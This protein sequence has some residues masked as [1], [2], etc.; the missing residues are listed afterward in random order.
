MCCVYIHMAFVICGNELQ[1]L[2]HNLYLVRDI[3]RLE[4]INQMTIETQL[5]ENARYHI[6]MMITEIIDLS[7]S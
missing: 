6:K 7:H 5:W 3:K 4:I 2:D 1:L